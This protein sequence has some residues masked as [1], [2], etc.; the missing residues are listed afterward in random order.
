MTGWASDRL[1]RVGRYLFALPLGLFGVQHVIYAHSP[2]LA[3]I[4]PHIAGS[5]AAAYVYGVVLLAA[6]VSLVTGWRAKTV[7]PTFGAVLLLDFLVIHVPRIL[8]DIGSGNL[9]TR[10]FETLALAATAF[11][12]GA[13]SGA[14]DPVVE[15]P[16]PRLPAQAGRLLFAACLVQSGVQHFLRFSVIATLVP[17]W[18]PART[19]LAAVA[20]AGFLTAAVSFGCGRFMRLSGVLLATMFLIFVASVHAPRVAHDLHDGHQWANLLVPVC[21]S[22]AALIFAAVFSPP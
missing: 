19:I 21:L 13:A 20:G 10:G 22:G 3:N 6:S 12:L 1:L 18:M 2:D 7:A 8:A 16:E 15:R 4:P 9:R 17:S 11:V 14:T 5:A